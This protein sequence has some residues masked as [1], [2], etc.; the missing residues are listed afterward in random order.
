[1]L[2]SMNE[3]INILLPNPKRKRKRNVL[4]LRDTINTDL[5]EIFRTSARSNSKY[6][7]DLKIAQ[8]TIA[9]TI[10]FFTGLRVNEMRYFQE[11]DI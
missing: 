10:L 1:M 4:P 6:K 5:F 7:Q 3:K 9:Y 8:L 2:E 11:H